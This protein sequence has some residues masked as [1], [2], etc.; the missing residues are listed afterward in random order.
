MCNDQS[1]IKKILKAAVHFFE[2]GEKIFRLLAM[3]SGKNK[4]KG[5]KRDRKIPQKYSNNASKET[6]DQKFL[7]NSKSP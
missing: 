7:D 3:S 2:L 5:S 4:G 6:L 1:C